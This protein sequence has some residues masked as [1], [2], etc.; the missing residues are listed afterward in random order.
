MLRVSEQHRDIKRDACYEPN[1]RQCCFVSLIHRTLFPSDF[2]NNT[3]QR[4]SSDTRKCSYWQGY[5]RL[6][7]GN[8]LNFGLVFGSCIM[9]LAVVWRARCPDVSSQKWMDYEIVPSAIFAMLDLVR[10]LAVIRTGE[11][12]EGLQIVDAQ[13]HGRLSWEAC[14]KAGCTDILNSQNTGTLSV[15]L[16]G[17]SLCDEDV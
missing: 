17:T 6:F 5:A 12:F 11:R 13:R 3:K 16:S 15:F 1:W 14:R 10:I 8:G 9:T 2:L 7:V 4:T